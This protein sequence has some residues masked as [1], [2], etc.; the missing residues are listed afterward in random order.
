MFVRKFAACLDLPSERTSFMEDPFVGQW[1]PTVPQICTRQWRPQMQTSFLLKGASIYDVRKKFGFFTP[2]LLCHVQNSCNLVPFVCFLGAPP[3]T[4]YGRHI[5]KFSSL[6]PLISR[7][8]ASVASE[9]SL[10]TGRAP[11]FIPSFISKRLNR[12]TIL[13]S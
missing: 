9:Y 12:R 1:P 6:R 11:C 3:P 8:S 7:A 4:H 5:W 10:L 2:C 13:W